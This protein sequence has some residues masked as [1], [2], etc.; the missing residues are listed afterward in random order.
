MPPAATGPSR[1]DQQPEAAPPRGSAYATNAP[2]MPVPTTPAWLG[3][4]FSLAGTF[5]EI[6]KTLRPVACAAV[7]ILSS[8]VRRATALNAARI[9]GRTLGA[10]E[11][12]RFARAVVGSFFDFVLDVA[13][14]SRLSPEELASLV[15]D[16][17]GLEAYRA[18]RSRGTGAVLVTAHL[19]T[20]EVGL[21]TL[22][23]EERRVRVVF[24]RDPSPSFE[25]LRSRLHKSLGVIE[26]PIDEGIDCWLALKDAL[27]HN[28][29]VVMQGD[30]A[31]PGQRSAVVP[32]LHGH[33]RLPTGPVRLAQMTGAPIVPVFAVPTTHG[34]FKVLLKDPIDVPAL[35]SVDAQTIALHQLASA[36]AAVVAA[37]PHQWLAFEPL[38]H[39]SR[40]DAY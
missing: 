33:L 8:S 15:D 27:E 10:A 31:V 39:E 38:F 24:K 32:F 1:P 4:F 12:R 3:P 7:P 16:V 13:R 28:E 36:M 14:S 17:Q 37:H 11:Q 21:A 22:V 29:V 9:F 40:A 26:T 2:P 5:P 25:R 30:R 34:T 18:A 20:F 35:G 19:G 6:A 23:R